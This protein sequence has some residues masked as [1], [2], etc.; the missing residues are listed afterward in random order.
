M[1][2]VMCFIYDEIL[3]FISIFIVYNCV[4]QTETVSYIEVVIISVFLEL[5]IT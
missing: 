5:C 4:I 2:F 1:L 3:S